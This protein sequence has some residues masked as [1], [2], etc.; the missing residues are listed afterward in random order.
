LAGFQ[1]SLIGRFWTC[2]QGVALDVIIL[3]TGFDAGTGGLT[4]IDIRGRDGRSL[5]EEWTREVRTTLGL[6][7]HGYPNLSATSAPYAPASAFCNAPTC[8]QHQVDWITHCIDHLRKTRRQ[9]IEPSA[10]AEQSWIAHHDE[11]AGETLVAKTKSWYTGAN[12]EGKQ[13]RLIGYIG[14]L[15]KYIEIWEEAKQR[16]YEGFE[17]A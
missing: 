1:T 16:D 12:I 4:A 8:L 2:P 14:G 10:E 13:N 6:M 5:R 7:I 17:M 3:A 9:V 11:T 15:P